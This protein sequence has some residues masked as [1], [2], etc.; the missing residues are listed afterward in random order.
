M[1]CSNCFGSFSVS[2][3]QYTGET[4]VTLV[5]GNSVKQ[6]MKVNRKLISEQRSIGIQ[7]KPP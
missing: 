1:R 3:F 5:V 4:L 6:Y 2:V 7:V